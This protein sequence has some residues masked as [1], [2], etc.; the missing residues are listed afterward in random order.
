MVNNALGFCYAAY[1]D[2]FYCYQFSN[3]WE[4]KDVLS[5]DDIDIKIL[6]EGAAYYRLGQKFE[7]LIESKKIKNDTQ[8]S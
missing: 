4:S 8:Y 6:M 7:K 3:Y 2:I 1:C 5:V